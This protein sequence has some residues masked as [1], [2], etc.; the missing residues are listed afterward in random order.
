MG[1]KSHPIVSSNLVGTYVA[2]LN[3][4]LAPFR[5]NAGF[6]MAIHATLV[7]AVSSAPNPTTAL[8]Q[9][10]FATT[11]AAVGPKPSHHCSFQIL[12]VEPAA[13]LGLHR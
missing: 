9:Q 2:K 1:S 4:N 5:S 13:D 10:T 12:I 3:A 7:L 11:T 8:L 6:W